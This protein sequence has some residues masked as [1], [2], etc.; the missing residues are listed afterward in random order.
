MQ[1]QQAAMMAKEMAGAV[2]NAG[3]VDKVRELVGA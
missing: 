2:K 1:A 3:G